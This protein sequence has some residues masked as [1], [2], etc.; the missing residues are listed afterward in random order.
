MAR[1]RKKSI[2][3]PFWSSVDTGMV[4]P[5]VARLFL[6]IDAL[7]WR[8]RG[9]RICWLGGTLCERMPAGHGVELRSHFPAAW[10]SWAARVQNRWLWTRRILSL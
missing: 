5:Y 2:R 4:N 10:F 6:R 7:I 8:L 9:K 1:Y 3:P